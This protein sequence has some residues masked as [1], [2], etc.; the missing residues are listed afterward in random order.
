MHVS[1]CL[2]LSKGRHRQ[3]LTPLSPVRTWMPPSVPATLS[4]V[5]M[6]TGVPPHLIGVQLIGVV[7]ADTEAHARSAARLVHVEYSDLPAV[8]STTQWVNTAAE[9]RQCYEV[10]PPL[11][12]SRL[13]T[14]GPRMQSVHALW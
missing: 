7:V 14:G 6:K 11:P 13:R 5:C 9:E 8:L 3:L 2:G 10:G 12:R 1:C 4:V